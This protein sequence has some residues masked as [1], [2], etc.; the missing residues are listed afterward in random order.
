[1]YHTLQALTDSG[2]VWPA[3]YSY[4]IRHDCI[5]TPQFTQILAS[6]NLITVPENAAKISILL[7]TFWAFLVF[8]DTK[9]VDAQAMIIERKQETLV[10]RGISISFVVWIST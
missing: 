1:M 8:F 5:R 6:E 7:Q 4:E 9:N 3:R 10:L 2:L